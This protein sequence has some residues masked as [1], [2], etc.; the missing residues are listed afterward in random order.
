MK[1][2]GKL[3]PLL[4]VLSEC[5]CGSS[6][7]STTDWVD[8][9]AARLTAEEVAAVIGTEGSSVP[10]QNLPGFETRAWE[11]D[12]VRVTGTFS[13]GRAVTLSIRFRN[14]FSSARTDSAS[15]RGLEKTPRPSPKS[16][17]SS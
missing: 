2:P 3:L 5:A 6:P 4:A 10:G 16:S 8:Q 1:T 11:R 15:C 9:L 12:Q 13:N 7:R 14:G 17:L